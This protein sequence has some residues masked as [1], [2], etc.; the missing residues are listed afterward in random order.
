MLLN[1]TRFLSLINLCEGYLEKRNVK[2]GE[3]GKTEGVL[4]RMVKF[5]LK[6]IRDFYK[7]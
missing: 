6:E 5:D 1:K 3:I 4:E 2:G 7:H